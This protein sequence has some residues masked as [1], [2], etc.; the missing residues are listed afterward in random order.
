MDPGDKVHNDAVVVFYSSPGSLMTHH[1]ISREQLDG[2][3]GYRA[4]CDVTASLESTLN[5]V[6]PGSLLSSILL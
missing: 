4:R 1:V 5:R 3:G 6:Q 2:L